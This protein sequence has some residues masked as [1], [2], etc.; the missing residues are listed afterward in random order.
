MIWLRRR[1]CQRGVPFE[2]REKG[3]SP[4]NYLPD[5]VF[6]GEMA[7]YVLNELPQK[8]WER[9]RKRSRREGWA[10]S[11]LLVE[12]MREYGEGR[13]TLAAQPPASLPRTSELLEVACPNGHAVKIPLS[14]LQALPTAHLDSGA[15]ARCRSCGLHVFLSQ[16]HRDTITAWMD[17]GP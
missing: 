13:L 17:G 8:V 10:L 5:S 12:L 16:R 3:R 9:F 6:L 15:V 11:P 1:P 14:K 7:S 4:C 2:G